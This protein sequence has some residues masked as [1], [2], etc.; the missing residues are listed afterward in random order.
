MITSVTLNK[1]PEKASG[2]TS[3][4]Q[5]NATKEQFL[6]LLVAQ[7]QH[8]DPLNPMDAMQFTSQLAQFSIVEQALE[9]NEQLKTLNLY[10][11][12][13]NN[14]RAVNLIGKEILAQGDKLNI[15]DSGVG[16][17]C[18][19][20]LGESAQTQAYVYD[21]TGRL[22]R[23]LDLGKRA[24]GEH[25]ISWDGLDQQG[26]ALG[27]G[28]YSFQVVARDVKGQMVEVEQ[29][30]RG[31]AQAATFKEGVTSLLVN[32]VVVPLGSILEVRG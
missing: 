31:R 21:S 25:S 4:S 17:L 6:R 16:Q 18:F 27:Y 15:G 7:L 5:A 22:V 11:A 24:A 12:S 32:G 8:Q 19:R 9:T 3:S 2:N 29:Y 28:T 23:T 20:L 26:K 10:E 14:A 30:L 13:A 1:S